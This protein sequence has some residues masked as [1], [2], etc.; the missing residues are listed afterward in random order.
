[1]SSK[2]NFVS[3]GFYKNITQLGT[4]PQ[5]MDTTKEHIIF[6]GKNVMQGKLDKGRNQ[7]KQAL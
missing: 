5:Q 3:T 2:I 4:F 1:M 7:I 6:Q